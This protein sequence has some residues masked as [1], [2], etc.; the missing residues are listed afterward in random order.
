[1]VE[2]EGHPANYNVTDESLARAPDHDEWL[3]DEALKDTFPASDPPVAIMPGSTLAKRHQSGGGSKEGAPQA[4]GDTNT[5]TSL[6][7]TAR[8]ARSRK[9]RVISLWPRPSFR[10][11]QLH[12]SLITKK[13]ATMS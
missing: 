1:M 7:A 10:H 6:P 9:I 12:Y 11:H 3:L 13:H 5:R 2:Q 4:G 8:L